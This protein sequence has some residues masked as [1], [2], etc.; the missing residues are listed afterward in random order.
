MRG[1]PRLALRLRVQEGLLHLERVWGTDGSRTQ[2]L[3]GQF[4]RTQM[5]RGLSQAP[6]Q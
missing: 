6:H 1:S 4:S 2:A 5:A 3:R